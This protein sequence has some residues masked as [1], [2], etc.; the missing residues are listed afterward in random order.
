MFSTDEVGG[1]SQRHL[2]Q[3]RRAA[4]QQALLGHH[5][6]LRDQPTPA[7][8]RTCCSSTCR[9]SRS[10]RSS[11]DAVTKVIGQECPTC[12]LEQ[13]ST[14]LIA[15]MAGRHGLAVVSRC[16]PTRRSTTC[17]SR[18]GTWRPGCRRPSRAPAWGTGS[19]SSARVPNTEQLQ[20]LIDGRSAAYTLSV[21]PARLAGGGRHGRFSVGAGPGAKHDAAAAV[22]C[23]PKTVPNPAQDYAGTDEL[24]GPVQEAVVRYL[25]GAVPTPRRRSAMDLDRAVQ[26]LL[27]RQQIQDTLYRYASSDRRQGL[28][29]AAGAVRR[30]RRR[31]VRRRRAIQ[32]ADAIVAWID[33]DQRTARGSTTS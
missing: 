4:V 5:R 14:C 9:T 31:P 13:R 27:D 29:P 1:A 8:T 17:T 12:R 21:G 30:R 2:R 11:R 3:R 19:R 23:T 7:A 26:D 33:D 28:H 24:R 15:D 32:G 22:I 20:S 18:S 25:T 16:R 6:R 10:S